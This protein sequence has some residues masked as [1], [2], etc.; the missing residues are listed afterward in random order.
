M[1]NTPHIFLSSSLSFSPSFLPKSSSFLALFFFLANQL[2]EAQTRRQ[3]KLLLRQREVLQHIDE[4]LPL[5]SNI[6]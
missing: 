3:D 1:G 6:H 4:E 5:V 2:E